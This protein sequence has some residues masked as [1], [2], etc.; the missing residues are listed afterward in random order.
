[1]QLHAAGARLVTNYGIGI[2]HD[3]MGLMHGIGSYCGELTIGVAACRE[4]LPDPH[5]YADCISRSYRALKQAT[6]GA[7]RRETTH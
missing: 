2:P 1:M 5:F 3:G 4:M 6:V 7:S